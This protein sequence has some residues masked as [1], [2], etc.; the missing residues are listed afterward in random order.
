MT[1]DPNRP[2]DRPLYTETTETVVV[3]DRSNT[4]LWWIAGLLGLVALILLAWLLLGRPAEEAVIEDQLTDAEIAAEL[5]RARLAGEL[6]VAQA[7]AD[8]ARSDAAR[9]AAEAARAQ[10]EARAAQAAPQTV[11]IERPG[12]TEAP[13]VQVDEPVVTPPVQ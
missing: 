4:A 7:S 10:A 3:R 9:A 6:G 8:I 12:V 1:Y 11:I 2:E 5:D 13:P